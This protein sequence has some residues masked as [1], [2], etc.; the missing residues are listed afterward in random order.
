MRLADVPKTRRETR[1]RGE[2]VFLCDII[3][4]NSTTWVQLS[5]DVQISLDCTNFWALNHTAEKMKNIFLITYE[6]N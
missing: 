5:H 1:R 3:I 4:I 6:L 2:A